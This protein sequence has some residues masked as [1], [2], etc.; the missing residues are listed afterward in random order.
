MW[1]RGYRELKVYQDLSVGVYDA[2]VA[3]ASARGMTFAGHKPAPVPLAHVLESGQRSI[4]HLGGYAQLEGAALA[5]AVQLTVQHGTWV[6][7]T[8]AIQRSLNGDTPGAAR[9]RAVT[10]ALFD[11]GARLLVGT[12]AGID[13][14]APGVS[15]VEEME[16]MRRAGIPLARLVRM[17]TADA[18]EYLGLADEVGEVAP[19][20]RADLV[21]LAGDPLVS[22]DALRRPRGVHMGDGWIEMR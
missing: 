17:A 4:E 15:L 2:I 1:E 16:E 22:L 7:P 13:V 18:A 19:G 21:L 8:L 5:E 20:M 6:C 10:R 14:T 12:D 11:G 9:R 3:A